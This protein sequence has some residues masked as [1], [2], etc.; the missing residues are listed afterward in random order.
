MTGG[1]G[2]GQARSAPVGVSIRSQRKFPHW[3]GS[4]DSG[5]RACC[6]AGAR[7]PHHPMNT[8][9]ESPPATTGGSLPEIP[10]LK[11]VVARHF[12]AIDTE[13]GGLLP[14][15]HA[16]LSIAAVASWE[17]DPFHVFILP[18]TGDV[19][20]KEAARKNGYTPELWEARGAMSL[21]HALIGFQHWLAASGAIGCEFSALP[22]AH[23]AG[24]DRAFLDHAAGRT[25]LEIPL[26]HRW[27]CSQAALLLAQDAGFYDGAEFASLDTLGAVSGFWEKEKRAA[28]HDALQDARCCLHG[29]QYLLGLV[30]WWADS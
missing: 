26:S 27:R 9:T 16:L 3:P 13:T 5:E 4:G 6:R 24:F 10:P 2:V 15:R 14:H 7:Q 1:E 30:G 11:K 20:E 19:I 17:V 21:K 25:G 23:N 18:E 8:E 22:L 12:I 28:A 29:Y